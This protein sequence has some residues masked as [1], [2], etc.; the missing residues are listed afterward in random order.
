M[1]RHLFLV[2]LATSALAC[3]SSDG[4]PGTDLVPD[5]G[6]G[7]GGTDGFVFDT[8]NPDGLPPLGIYGITPINAVLKND[9]TSGAKGSQAYKVTKSEGGGPDVDITDTVT[10]NLDDAAIGSFAKNVFTC[11]DL[12]TGTLGKSTQIHTSPGNAI[13]NVTCIALRTTGDKRDF[14]FV[15]PYKKDPDPPKDILK[16]GTTIKQVDVGFVQDTTASMGPE[17]NNLRDSLTTIIASLKAAIPS[18]GLAIARHDDFPVSPFGYDGSAGGASDV[19]FQLLQGVTT[20]ESLAKSAVVGLVPYRG[21]ALPESQY[22]AQYQLLTGD[23]LTWTVAKA[24]SIAKHTPP[25]GTSGGADFRAG[26]LPVVVEIT[27]ASWFD[28]PDYATKGLTTHGRTDVIAAYASTKAKFVG[29]QAIIEKTPGAGLDTPC[30]DY[31]TASCDSAR[32]YN[33]AIDLATQTGSLVDPTVFGGTCPAGKCCTGVGGAALNPDSTGKCPLVYRAKT[34][35][36][37]VADSVVKAIQAISVGSSFDVTAIPSNDP[38]NPPDGKGAPVDATKFI[39]SIRAMEEGDAT[40][41]C[42]S[43]AAKDTDADGVKDTFI[44]VT[45]GTPVCFEVNAK[46]NDFVEPIPTPQFFNAFID[47]VGMPGS[48]KLDRRAVLFLVPPK[49]PGPAK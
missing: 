6:G 10:F 48:V 17:I 16:F 30:T 1:R 29:I 4:T 7:D 11:A 40:S 39:K 3:S 26:S 44:S 12:P 31:S 33:Q 38:A 45:V 46:M 37:G 23:G 19:P 42:P 18:V 21:G 13:A 27:D 8:D 32:G 41:G 2:A 20:N 49:E 24:G 25:A 28:K 15:V 14:F 9:L 47:V 43:H 36:T 5:T 35:G 22:E 34:D